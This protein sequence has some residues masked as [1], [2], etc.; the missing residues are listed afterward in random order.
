[1]KLQSEKRLTKLGKMRLAVATLALLALAAGVAAEECE[2]ATEEEH[3]ETPARN[4]IGN[5]ALV[6][7]SALQVIGTYY[8]MHKLEAKGWEPLWVIGIE[9]LGQGACSGP[10]VPTVAISPSPLSQCG[11]MPR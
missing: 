3:D 7:I 9:V 8:A 11:P 10:T 5:L 1:M 2:C 6:F 4:Q